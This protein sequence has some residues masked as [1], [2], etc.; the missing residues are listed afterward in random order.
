MRAWSSL[1]WHDIID[2]VVVGLIVS[3]GIGWA[4]VSGFNC[5]LKS[6]LGREPKPDKRIPP[7]VTGTVERLIFMGL[8]IIQPIVALP[9]MG[10]WLTLKMAANWNKDIPTEAPK[11][12]RKA[13]I[14]EKLNWNSHAFLG[15]LTGLLSMAFAGA[16]GML[17]RLIMG[18]DVPTFHLAAQNAANVLADTQSTMPDLPTAASVLPIW[19]QYMQALGLPIFAAV[20][21]GFGAWIGWQ[22]MHTASVKLQHDLFDR[23]WPVLKATTHLLAEAWGKGRVDEATMKSYML[24]VAPTRFV[25]DDEVFRYLQEVRER[26]LELNAIKDKLD[27]LPAGEEKD[28]WAAKAKEQIAWIATYV[29][30]IE[31]KFDPYLRLDKRKRS[32]K[33]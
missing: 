15:L 18:L 30:V 14:A 32:S 21:A 12:D 27:Q 19:V 6:K 22:Q 29:N 7:G 8:T 25:F 26:V 9:S 11:E 1:P 31:N 17:A 5:C 13:V 28:V 23:R 16:G 2:G 3:L 4:V 20:I 33:L 24:D 10:V